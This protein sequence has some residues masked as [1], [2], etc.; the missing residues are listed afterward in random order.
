[1]PEITTQPQPTPNQKSINWK[2]ILIGAVIG[3]VAIGLGVLIFLLLQPKD[4]ISSTVTTKKATPSV[5]IST[6]SAKKDETSDWKT[7]S[8]KEKT[9][10]LKYPKEWDFV[11][12]NPPIGKSRSIVIAQEDVVGDPYIQIYISSRNSDF[13][14]YKKL[15]ERPVG[16]IV[17]E[18]G[19]VHPWVSK[20]RLENLTVDGY[21]TLREQVEPEQEGS[22][23]SYQLIVL[24]NRENYVLDVRQTAD[25]KKDF[26]SSQKLFFQILSTFKLLD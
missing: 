10:T 5:K 15:A 24:I 11:R 8:D 2:N 13:D 26:D 3:A 16:S 17:K 18:G 6:P 4:E 21:I 19:P 9:I 20:K 23:A 1:M 12:E 25:T 22:R 7:F 14:Y